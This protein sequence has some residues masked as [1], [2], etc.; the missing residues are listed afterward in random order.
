[1]TDT[2]S[3]T[4]ARV[5][6]LV[7][8]GRAIRAVLREVAG[9]RGAPIVSV[10]VPYDCGHP[11]GELHT[12]LHSATVDA[13]HQLGVSGRTD[14]EAHRMLAPL[15]SIDP[16]GWGPGIEGIAAFVRH[17]DMRTIP[18][19]TSVATSVRVGD[20]A[21]VIGSLPAL[22]SAEH[23]VLFVSKHDP[24]LLMIANRARWLRP[25]SGRW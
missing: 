9:W 16:T 3:S 15:M 14:S 13:L 22:D 25:R 4:D 12:R 17:G 5:P 8:E 23:L 11:I 19:R 10:Y 6:T 18:L 20:R 1:M 2:A 21:D 7:L 24:V